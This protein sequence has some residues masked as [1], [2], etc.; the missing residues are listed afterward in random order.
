[1]NDKDDLLI[2]E[3]MADSATNDDLLNQL[4]T[5]S[6]LIAVARTG[7]LSL[8]KGDLKINLKF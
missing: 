3:A 5:I 8:A 6:K 4:K 7:P 1:M 2:V